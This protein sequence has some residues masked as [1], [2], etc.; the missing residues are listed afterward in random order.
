MQFLIAAILSVAVLHTTAFTFDLQARNFKCF[1]EDLPQD[2]QLGGSYK[3]ASG[4]SQF[5][6]FRITDPNGAYIHSDTGKDS[7]EFHFSTTMGGEYAFC[8]YNRMVT[9]VK[10]VAGMKRTINFDLRMGAD[11]NDYTA[12]AKREHLKPL[13]IEMRIMEDTVKA[14][15]SEYLFFKE[16]ESVMRD[17]NEHLNARAAWITVGS[18]GFVVVFA[19]WQVRHMKGFFRTKRLID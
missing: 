4:Y 12:I 2:Y 18:M 3:A 16:R 9:G 14:V 15:H 5:I 11:A 7:G 1:T 19:W 10:Y 13:E 8:F 17:T 6:D